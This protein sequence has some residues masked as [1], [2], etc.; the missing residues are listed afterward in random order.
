MYSSLV[1]LQQLLERYVGWQLDYQD[2]LY[3]PRQLLYQGESSGLNGSLIGLDEAI[4]LR[5]SRGP[6]PHFCQV[7][8][9]IG[10]SVLLSV[11]QFGPLMVVASGSGN[12]MLRT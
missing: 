8:S 12:I 2:L 6:P 7:G 1:K 3:L 9:L 5:S 11:W 4:S 10:N